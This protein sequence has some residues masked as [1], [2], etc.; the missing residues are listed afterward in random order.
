MLLPRKTKLLTTVPSS[1]VPVLL[2]VQAL[3]VVNRTN[4]FAEGFSSP[5]MNMNQLQMPLTEHGHD[6][7]ESFVTMRTGIDLNKTNAPNAPPANDIDTT[8]NDN[9]NDNDNSPYQHQHTKSNPASPSPSP[10]SSEAVYWVGEGQ[11][12]ESP[13]GKVI[14]NIEGFDVS[15]GVLIDPH[16]IRQFSRKIF[17][18][19]DP[20][21]NELLTEY[22]GQPVKPIKYDW[23]VFDLKRGTNPL[24]PAMVPILPSVVKGPRSVPCMPVMPRHAGSD[25]ILYQCPLFIDIETPKGTYQAWEMYDYTL[26]LTHSA[27]RPPSL[28]W[29][30]QGSSPP[31][32]EDGMGVMHFL[33]HRM[34]SFEELPLR[35][36]E[37][38]EEEYG[39]FRFPPVDMEEIHQLEK[40]MEM[41]MNLAKADG[42]NA[43]VSGNGNGNGGR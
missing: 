5:N 27:T 36:R 10:G 24:D 33:G 19:R 4:T 2:L 26:D 42:R 41:M 32:I 6:T 13:S 17:W 22:N 28:S 31:F 7:F 34:D 37:L 20:I 8:S 12:Y 15:K 18:F 43:V 21:T 40:E 16:H 1:V 23:Q 11:L 9:D 29:S 30:R 25:V 3:L 35:M 38:V 39:L 14:A